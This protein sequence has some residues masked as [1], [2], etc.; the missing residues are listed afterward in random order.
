MSANI[1]QTL[2]SLEIGNFIKETRQA[3]NLTQNDL[4][5]L[6]NSTQSSIARL[7]KGEQNLTT[8]TLSKI[9]NALNHKI[10]SLA[11][12]S[13]DFEVQGGCELSGSI[14]TNYSKNGAMGL[15]CASLLNLGTT[16][17]HGIP[18]IEEVNRILEVMHSI[19]VNYVW[20]TKNT[21]QINRPKKLK[22]EN[23]NVESASRTRTILMF[24]GAL[25]HE[26]KEFTLPHSEGCTLGTRTITPHL[27]GLEKLNIEIKVTD[28]QYQI[29]NNSQTT[30]TQE[31][32]EIIMYEASDTGTELLMIAAAKCDKPVTIKYASSNYMVQDVGLF[33]QKLGVTVTNLG[34]ST[35]TI[36]GIKKIEKDVEFYNSEDP[37]ES[38][39]FISAAICTNSTLNIT[40][41]PIEF[42][43]LELLKLSKMGLKYQKSPEYLSYNGWTKLADITIY[44]STLTA[45]ADKITCGAYPDI[46]MD[47][48]PFFVPIAT[49]A[50][51]QTLI[52]DWV[53]ENRAI[54]FT[55][56]NRLGCRVNLAD[57]H[58]VYIQG[59]TKFKPAQV[60]CPPA[61]RPAMIIL[62]AML[63][64]DGVS[65][66][67]NVYSIR[68][69]YQE[70]TERLN[71]IG[72]N[73]KII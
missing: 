47:N 15:L 49:Q 70:I 44:P 40:R 54:Y 43:E 62:I 58:R 5:K 39:M 18:R 64:A 65:I 51:G 72:A 32:T 73:I 10:I 71:S 25:I 63:G 21:L 1:N 48:L 13:I 36:T 68:R 16:T 22:L 52:H 26:Y 60:V 35:M 30:K 23:I 55:E 42:L 2:S 38:M 27:Y 33:L 66:L 67:R 59:G 41:C 31:K 61:L 9:S 19:G 69:G 56:L 50:I 3:R 28:N 53:Y 6:I 46:N 24:I 14:E 4:A 8:E 37:I 17:L 12:K 45:L 29:K 34:Q 57:P 11:P 20:L 7:E